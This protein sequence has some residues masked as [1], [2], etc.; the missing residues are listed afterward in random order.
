MRIRVRSDYRRLAKKPLEH[1]GISANA[2]YFVIGVDW[3]SY[4]IINNHGEPILY[5]KEL[6]DVLDTC[7]PS[8]WMLAEHEDDAWYFDPEKVHRPGFYEDWHGSDGD[9]VAQTAARRTLRDE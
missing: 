5:P 3:D 2:D 4:R 8:G 1:P 9:R 6:F 7:I